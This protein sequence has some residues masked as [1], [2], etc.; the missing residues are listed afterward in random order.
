LINSSIIHSIFKGSGN[1]NCGVQEV[2][3]GNGWKKVGRN[4][5]EG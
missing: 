4:G 2:E 5:E 1:D 3:I